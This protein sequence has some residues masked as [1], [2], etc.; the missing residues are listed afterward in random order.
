VCAEAADNHGMSRW[1]KA[2][3]AV[4]RFLVRS[5]VY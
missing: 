2:V 1:T 5:R 3:C 4:I